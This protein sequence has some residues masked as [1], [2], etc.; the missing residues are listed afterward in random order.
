[1]IV[2]SALLALN[3]TTRNTFAEEDAPVAQT[4]NHFVT[5]HDQGE[6]L[7]IR[8]D[9]PTVQDAIERAGL[10]L[11]P[12]D[13]VD[14]ALD[15]PINADNFHINIHRARPV[16]IIDGTTK[17]QLMSASYDTATNATEAGFAI[18]DG[19][20]IEL[21]PTTNFLEV[22]A[23]TTYRIVRNGGQTV[24]VETI[25]PYA[26]ETIKDASL[27]VGQSKLVQMGEDGLKVAHYQVNFK[28]GVEVSRELISEEVTRQPV[29]RITAEGAKK[30]IPPERETC[31]NWARQAGVSE[32]DLANAVDLI[33]RESGCRPNAT[34]S[35]SGAYGIPQAL[36]GNKMAEMGADWQTNPVTQIRWMIKYVNSRYGGWTGAMNW[37]YSHGWY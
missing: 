17:K 4:S 10:L 36:P 15:A 25:I 35:S 3:T 22:G 1:M 8:T 18:Y 7:T 20:K 26:E 24:T 13:L 21:T 37:W 9:A 33:Y 31:A 23:S 34:N 28:D 11:D 14:P 32:A 19:D 29:S 27:D 6:A 16:F 12:S 5:L 2:L 30:S